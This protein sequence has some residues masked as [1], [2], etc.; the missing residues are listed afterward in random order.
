MTDII[1]KPAKPAQH[2]KIK[3]CVYLEFKPIYNHSERMAIFQKLMR[4]QP[5]ID[6]FLSIEFGNNL[7][8]ENKTSSNA[9][10]IIDFASEEALQN[11]ADHPEHK[12]IGAQ[13]VEMAEGGADAI[14]VYDILVA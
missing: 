2:A 10:F 13:L 14:M 1:T 6:G 7:D 9:G 8:L 5:I 3:H 12:K 4:L 11:Y